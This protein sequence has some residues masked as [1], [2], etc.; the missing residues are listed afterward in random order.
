[1]TETPKHTINT[2]TEAYVSCAAVL[3]VAACF[4][5]LTHIYS[6]CVSLKTAVGTALWRYTGR[7]K[8]SCGY[9]DLRMPIPVCLDAHRNVLGCPSRFMR[10]PIRFYLNTNAYLS[11]TYKRCFLP[12]NKFNKHFN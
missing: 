11:S 9:S 5:L 10:M 4:F 7:N 6:V 2:C 1:M 3:V 12:R 8:F